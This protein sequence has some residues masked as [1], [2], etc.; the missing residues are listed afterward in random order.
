MLSVW[1]PDIADNCRFAITKQ[2]DCRVFFGG[3]VLCLLALQF[4]VSSQVSLL[5]DY[6]FVM[7]GGQR[8]FA[9]FPSRLSPGMPVRVWG[10]LE[11]APSLSDVA[12]Y[13]R[14][15]SAGLSAA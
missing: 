13:D 5:D 14:S 6:R 8:P 3:N 7:F 11:V 12:F 15:A 1:F 2:M 9:S 4:S 10:S